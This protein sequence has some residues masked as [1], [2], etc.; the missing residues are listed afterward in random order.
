MYITVSI[1]TRWPDMPL[2][3]GLSDEREKPLDAADIYSVIV[4][5][6]GSLSASMGVLENSRDGRRKRRKVNDGV[7]IQR[8]PVCHFGHNKKKKEESRERKRSFD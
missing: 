8:H 4:R 1:C 6:L 5:A 2:A 7:I 3:R